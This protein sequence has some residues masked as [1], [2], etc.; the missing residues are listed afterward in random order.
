MRRYILAFAAALLTLTTLSPPASAADGYA[1]TSLTVRAGPNGKYP[2]IG[3]ISP[4]TPVNVISCVNGWRW[5]D[6]STRGFRGWV[7]GNY[8]RSRYRDRDD[9]VSS[10]GRFLGLPVVTYNE[11]S[12]WGENYYDRDFYRTRYGWH[13]DHRD[14]GW[15]KKHGKWVR[16]NDRDG[17][18]NH[19][20]RD[21]DNDGTRD[22]RDRDDDN[23][24]VRDSRDHDDDNNGVRDSR[25]RWNYNHSSRHGYNN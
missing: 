12:Y 22:R 2:A 9:T 13:D 10:L 16:D 14:Y 20:D 17:V 4:H 3:R 23:D 6:V 25:D 1:S 18:S 24:G 21:D 19:Y 5:C 7:A 11:R 15:H 8:I